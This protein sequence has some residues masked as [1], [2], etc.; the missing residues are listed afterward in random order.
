MKF[1]FSGLAK[2]KNLIVI[3][4]A[5][6]IVCGGSLLGVKSMTA[7]FQQQSNTMLT[8][9]MPATLPPTLPSQT[10]TESTTAEATTTTAPTT[11][12]TTETTTVEVPTTSQSLITTFPIDMSTTMPTT[13]PTTALPTTTTERNLT[14]PSL[15]I[16]STTA[17]S[18]SSGGLP[19]GLISGLKPNGVLFDDGIASYQYNKT[20]NYYYTN[21]DPWQRALGYNELYDNMA[22]FTAIYIDTMRCKFRYDNKDWMIQFWK[23]QYGYVFIGHEI[24]VYYKPIDRTTEH[25]DCV[26]DEDSL[27]M[28]MNGLRKGEIIYSRDYGKYW[29]CTGFVPGKLDKFSDRSELAIDCRITMK[30]K[31]M[32]GA[33]VGSLDSNGLIRGEDYKIKGLD[34]YIVW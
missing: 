29:W 23:G 7:T 13:L 9:D 20:G 21:E 1:D 8:T 15:Q 27:Y 28:S 19:S 5:M 34:V 17:S 3:F 30:D 24:G 18:G 11:E 33:F 32:L 12:T 31:D 10:T 2:N 26:S 14:L 22:A 16:P 4:M 6:L 25:Y